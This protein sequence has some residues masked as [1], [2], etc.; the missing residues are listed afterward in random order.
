MNIP[1]VCNSADFVNYVKP[2][3]TMI[4]MEI[5]GAILGTSGG[6]SGVGLDTDDGGTTIGGG[7]NSG[8][9]L[10]NRKPIVRR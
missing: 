5:E 4:E 8:G 7:N 9:G 1:K 2:E 3:V 10:S 6:G